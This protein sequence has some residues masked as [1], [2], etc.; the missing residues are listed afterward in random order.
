M[1]EK[2]GGGIMGGRAGEE[3]LDAHRNLI[4][5]EKFYTDI[6][7]NIWFVERND[8]GRFIY[9]GLE[10]NKPRILIPGIADTFFLIE[11]P[12]GYCNRLSDKTN[13]MKSKLEQLAESKVE[14]TKSSA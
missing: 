7:Q 4:E 1:A 14:K 8:K 6:A 11:D 5:E 13:W 10:I 2:F 3:Y 9:S 12:E